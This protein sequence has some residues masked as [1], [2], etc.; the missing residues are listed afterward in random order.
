MRR[1][2]RRV[3]RRPRVRRIRLVDLAHAR[4]GDKGD[5][6]NV[7]VIAKRPADYALLE[8][9][10]TAARVARHFKG[11]DPGTGRA[12]RAAQPA[13]A[14]LPA[15]WGARRRRHHLAQDRRARA[16]CSPRRCSGWRSRCADERSRARHPRGRGAHRHA[17]SPREEERDRRAHDRRLVRLARATP[18]STRRYASSRLARGGK[19]L[20]RRHGSA[21]IARLGGPLG[22]REPGRRTAVRRAVRADARAAE[23]GRGAWCRGAPSPVGCGLATACDLVLAGDVGAVRVSRSAAR[24]RARRS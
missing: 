15:P 8:R 19:R 23:A 16:R 4:S 7:G 24:I 13:R 18:I 2:R 12:V 6:A 10:V 1:P 9:H 3:T 14:Q 17:Q 21:G 5:T 20:L 22:R 11:D